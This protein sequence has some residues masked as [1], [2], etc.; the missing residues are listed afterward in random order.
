MTLERAGCQVA[1]ATGVM[2]VAVS[3]G[4][5]APGERG[6]RSGP[7]DVRS[8]LKRQGGTGH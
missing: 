3:I 6:V 7:G 5:A 1:R 4:L 8:A 2:T